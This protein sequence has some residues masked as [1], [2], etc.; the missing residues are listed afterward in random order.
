MVPEPYPMAL[1]EL[2]L[3][4]IFGSSWRLRLA[5]EF[6]AMSSLEIF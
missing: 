4:V 3:D 5:L 2:R 6:R 1:Q